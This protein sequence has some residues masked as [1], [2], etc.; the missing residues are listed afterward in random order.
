MNEPQAIALHDIAHVIFNFV[1]II[2]TIS[3][4]TTNLYFFMDTSFHTVRNFW[5]KAFSTQPRTS[6]GCSRCINT[7][8]NKTVA[9]K[10]FLYYAFV[11]YIYF[12]VRSFRFSSCFPLMREH[13][14]IKAPFIQH[15]QGHVGSYDSFIF[16]CCFLL[17]KYHARHLKEFCAYFTNLDDDKSWNL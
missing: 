7:W 13:L 10:I 9:A 6:Y 17:E 3:E 1:S 5:F 15:V 4:S 8:V 2:C 11:F 12:V 16:R 14:R